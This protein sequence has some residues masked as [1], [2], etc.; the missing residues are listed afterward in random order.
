MC[1][2]IVKFDD[3]YPRSLTFLCTL[4][5]SSAFS[6]PV[7]PFGLTGFFLF[8]KATSVML[9]PLSLQANNLLK[10][11]TSAGT[12]SYRLSLLLA[13]LSLALCVRLLVIG[14]PLLLF[15]RFHWVV[16]QIKLNVQLLE[17]AKGLVFFS[18][19]IS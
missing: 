1:M 19:F 10:R 11:G 13:L 8:V 18:L 7:F 6:R 9:A 17:H 12:P 3:N 2:Y 15:R 16:H 14:Y 4:F 5:P